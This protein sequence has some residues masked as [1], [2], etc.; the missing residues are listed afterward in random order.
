MSGYEPPKVLSCFERFLS[1]DLVE[2]CF[3]HGKMHTVDKQVCGNRFTSKF[4]ELKTN[5]NQTDILICGQRNIV[6]DKEKEYKERGLFKGQKIAFLYQGSKYKIDRYTNYDKIVCVVDSFVKY[7]HSIKDNYKIQRVLKDE[8]HSIEQTVTFRGRAM[9]EMERILKVFLIKG[10]AI[11]SVTATPNLLVKPPTIVIDNKLIQETTIHISQNV[12][13]S[14]NDILKRIKDRQQVLIFTQ[15]SHVVKKICTLAKRFDINYRG[16]ERMKSKLCGLGKYTFD[17]KSNIV[18][19]T[20]AAYEGWSSHVKNGCAYLFVSYDSEVNSML[21]SNIFQAVNRLREGSLHN[22]I[23][24]F[25]SRSTMKYF[26]N[27]AEILEHFKNRKTKVTEK[28]GKRYKFT[29][30]GH[31]YHRQDLQDYIYFKEDKDENIQMHIL[32]DAVKVHLEQYMASCDFKGTYAKFFKDRKVKFIDSINDPDLAMPESRV[33]AKQKIEHLLFTLP[34]NEDLIHQAL[35]R[36]NSIKDLNNL[37]TILSIAVEVKS[38]LYLSGFDVDN[39]TEINALNYITCSNFEKDILNLSIKSGLDSGKHTRKE[40]IKWFEESNIKNTC[41]NIIY[42]LVCGKP[43]YNVVGSREY[44]RFTSVPNELIELFCNRLGILFTEL[45]ISA[46]FPRIICSL[47]GKDVPSDIYG[48]ESL[49]K[50]QRT[51]NKI[52]LN[53]KL[54]DLHTPTLSNF[55]KRNRKRGKL[56]TK[57]Q[58][59]KYIYNKT[60]IDSKTLSKFFDSEIVEWLLNEF[61]K[62]NMDSSKFFDLMSKHERN[63]ISS[64]MRNLREVNRDIEF[65]MVRKHDAVLIFHKEYLNFKVGLNTEYRGLRNWFKMTRYYQ[66]IKD[67]FLQYLAA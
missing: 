57:G 9:L 10:C 43:S 8:I 49:S 60:G 34:N 33:K 14:I 47:F 28:Q 6:I 32:D 31:T 12:D 46:A 20:S 30:K 42:E 44:N 27:L 15:N 56:V 13:R 25:K 17:E 65:K 29:F 63:I 48:S 54:N 26:P 2:Q 38:G 7:Y 61:G 40:T 37:K 22:E 51:K 4:L 35:Y 59:Q 58:Y 67:E 1:I 3:E 50:K 39:T 64:C 24:F 18:I 21:G 62:G 5:F 19:C 41:L 11:T 53:I 66:V 55:K 45:D 52:S 16:G 23:V 36:D